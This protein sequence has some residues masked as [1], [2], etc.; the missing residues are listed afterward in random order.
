M[1]H[2]G[3][4]IKS[5]QRKIEV[6][7]LGD[8]AMRQ[9]WRAGVHDM[10]A[11]RFRLRIGLGIATVGRP[12]VLRDIV[13]RLAHQTCRPDRLIIC[14]VAAADVANLEQAVSSSNLLIETIKSAPGLPRQRNL[15]LNA[16]ADLDLLLFID[17]DFLMAPRYVEAV[18]AAFQRNAG[19]VAATGAPA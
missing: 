16:A 13:G 8:V 14:H 6:G 5:T 1:I 18:V 7:A 12:V 4:L 3:L 11:D 9:A 2:H 15:I 10:E 17:D 19:I